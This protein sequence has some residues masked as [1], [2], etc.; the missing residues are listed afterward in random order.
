MH[1]SAMVRSQSNNWASPRGTVNWV[2][3]YAGMT[4]DYCGFV[5]VFSTRWSSNHTVR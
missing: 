4:S 1:V 3:A 2:P 5:Y